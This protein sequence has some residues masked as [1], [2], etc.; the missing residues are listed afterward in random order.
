[1]VVARQVEIEP[2]HPA[3]GRPHLLDAGDR[4]ELDVLYPRAV[5]DQPGDA[6]RT[7]RWPVVGLLFGQAIGHF[8]DVLDQTSERVAQQLS[9]GVIGHT[10]RPYAWQTASTLLPS[11]SRTKA[12]K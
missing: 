3:T 11:G 1:G 5:P 2:V 10:R 12:A 9:N 8:V 4:G 7:R 6:V